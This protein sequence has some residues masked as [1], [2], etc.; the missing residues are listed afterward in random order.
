MSQSQRECGKTGIAIVGM[1]GRF[2]GAATVKEFWSNLAAGVESIRFASDEELVAAGVD[3]AHKDFIPASSV[4]HEPEFFDASF[5]GFSAREAE[6]IDPQQRVFLECAWEALED[7]ACDPGSYPGAIGVFAGA[8]MNTYG[9]V[10]LFSN[11]EIIGSVGP[12]QVMVGNDKDF[13]CSRVSYKLNLR[14]PSVGVQTACS[15]SLVAVQM[16]FESLLRHECDTAL[17]GGVSISLPQSSGYVYV[18]GMILS[19]DGHCRAF[20]AAASGTVPG[21]GAGVVVL[22]RLVDA[23]AD[24]DHMY[25]VIR[26]AAINND[27]SSKVGYSAPSVEGQ[28]AVI[29][30]SMRMAGFAPESVGYVEAHGTGTEVGD[31]IEVA[32][33]QKAFESPEA[34]AGSCALGS[35]KTNIGHLDTAAGV[36]G[37]IKAALSLDHRAIPPT[38]HFSKANP[39]IDFAKTP[40]YVNNALVPFDGA[41]PLRAGVSSFGI[42]GTNAHVSIEEAPPVVSDPAAASQLF[43]LSAKSSAALDKQAARLLGYLEENPSANLADMAF[44]LQKG[45]QAFRHRRLV[46]A[47]DVSQLKAGLQSSRAQS[48]GQQQMRTDNAPAEAPGVVFLFPGQGSQYVNMGRDLYRSTPAFRETVDACCEILAPHLE[49][50]LRTILYP[51]AGGEAEAERLLGRTAIT[52]PAL[53]II[54]YAT[55][56]LWMDVGVTPSAMVGHSIGEYVA[57]CV[58]GVFSLEDALALVAARGRLIQSA[59]G[60]TMLAVNLSEQDLEPL[61]SREIS[62]AAVNSPG[63]TV[64]S[65][66]EGELAALEATLRSKKIQC[67][68][69]RTSHAFHSP[70]MDAVVGDFVERVAAV[71][72]HTPKMRYLSN[73]SGTWITDRQA[74][75]PEYWGSHLRNT[76]RFADCGRNLLREPNDLMLEV[77]PG[78]TLLSLLR[79]QLEPRSARPLIASMRHAM[80]KQDD[81]ETWLSAM[82]RLWLSNVRLNWDGLHRGERRAR[83]SLPTYPFERQRY[84]VEPKKAAAPMA[85]TAAPEKQPDIA[86]WFYVPSWKR[87]A[88][89]FLLKSEV[90]AADTW[91]LLTDDEALAGALTEELSGRG[92]VVRVRAGG[93]FR[94]ISSELYEIDP[95]DRRDY[96][97]LIQELETSG[98]WPRRVVHAWMPD[99][100]GKRDPTRVL[101]RGVFSAMFLAQAVEGRSSAGMV[102]LNVVGN[103]AYSISGERICSPAAVAL[104]AFVG[105]V[106]LECPHF[107]CR[108]IDVDLEAGLQRVTQQL[109]GELVSVAAN[110]TV[111]YRGSARW[112][113]QYE[114]VRIEKPA[115]T[116]KNDAQISLRT[117]GTYLITGGLGGVGLVLAE[118]LA[119]KAKARIILTSRTPLPAASEW[120]GLLASSDT[121]DVV[122]RRIQ[123][124][125]SI[126][127][128]GGSVH[129][130]VADTT[131]REAMRQALAH[132]RAECGPIHGIVHA[133]GTA[134]ASMVQTKSREQ[135]LDVFMPKVQ[136][137]EWIRECLANKDGIGGELDFVML[138]SSISAVIPSFG[139]SDYAAANAYLDGFAAAFDEPR[140]TRVISANWDTWREVGMAVDTPLPEALAH[141]REGRLRHGILS[142][143]AEE[144]F[145]R[146]LGSPLS[147]VVVSTR[148]FKVLQRQTAE[149]IAQFHGAHQPSASAPAMTVHSRPDSMD[150]FSAAGDDIEQ[151][152][153]NVWQELLGIEPIGIHDNFFKLGGH[154]LLGTQVLARMRER[155]KIDLSLRI[156]FEA[157]TPAELAEHVRVMSWASMPAS[158]GSILE[159]EEIEI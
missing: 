76:V 95:A 147:Q 26:G 97:S 15:T 61:L 142:S 47:R 105:V 158:A 45:R 123:G 101:D 134:G 128:A 83:L 137:T 72:L 109:A 35:V 87:S 63:Q 117:G 18:P 90:D 111:A 6:I 9:V 59:P 151:F 144:V 8:G 32:A 17:A 133:A 108:V 28:T 2:P 37:L 38:L 10:N 73:V 159:R 14:G 25:A 156:I 96:D 30:K 153:V 116:G 69:L 127:E 19:R 94:R 154:S 88:P 40:F 13:L 110:E 75:N 77:G 140:G 80:A 141:L 89:Q 121:P 131:D 71:K 122:K 152:I 138:C 155:F 53:F 24:G 41:G 1:A 65:G 78:E 12:Y 93:G 5:F 118:H 31:P 51:E 23:I 98:R 34:R 107:R 125:R 16:A 39:L 124:I 56:K 129:V 146:L 157:A 148:D 57:A 29:Q 150:E 4:V 130:V 143:E 62:V 103:R 50:D 79:A 49:L 36:T 104:N 68:R 114:P 48:A 113:Q 86:D 21:A 132:V 100:S 115:A 91:L 64:A 60:G 7:A 46:V 70:M 27:G 42:G 92:T 145:D 52:Q 55:A 112:L 44:T 126:E 85:Q 66:P 43:V 11:P 20:D 102:E 99:S 58:A 149:A 135:A 84:W 54:E 120:E 33:L 22:K 67:K 136:G 106:A 119:R 139:L 74:T 3:A 81:R 82:G